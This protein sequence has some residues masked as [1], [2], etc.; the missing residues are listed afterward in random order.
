MS[1]RVEVKC[2][3]CD[4]K[5]VRDRCR[6]SGRHTACKVC[7]P[8]VRKCGWLS[9]NVEAVQRILRGKGVEVCAS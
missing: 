4:R 6:L 1:K 8:I 9:G 5:V 3:Y 7:L 2:T